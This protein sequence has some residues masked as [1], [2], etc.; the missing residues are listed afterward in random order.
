MYWF[1]VRCR[2]KPAAAGP[3][4][5][6]LRIEC[7]EGRASPS[8][9]LAAQAWTSA[10]DGFVPLIGILAEADPG[11]ASTPFDRADS[12]TPTTP[13]G[14]G[15]NPVPDAGAVARGGAA[16]P[17][18]VKVS[19]A[20]QAD[21]T[22]MPSALVIVQTVPALPADTRGSNAD[23]RRDAVP[24]PPWID[25]FQATH[26]PTQEG[27]YWIFSGEVIGDGVIGQ[28]VRFG[29]LGTLAGPPARTTS[30]QLDSTFNCTIALKP[31]EHGTATAQVTSTYGLDSNLAQTTI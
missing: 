2:S 13:A 8:N 22:G 24:V 11:R 17:P 5:A 3:R 21:H 12:V 19:A 7:L 27:N 30:V 14:A 29:G 16:R 10:P 28:P 31:G 9:L 25:N 18:G 15:S 23:G 26:E 20:A 4:H 6:R 1:H